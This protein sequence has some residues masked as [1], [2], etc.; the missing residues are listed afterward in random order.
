MRKRLSQ[1]AKLG[2][3]YSETLTKKKKKQSKTKQNKTKIVNKI[4][5]D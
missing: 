2:Y 1:E 4:F 3:K 5:A